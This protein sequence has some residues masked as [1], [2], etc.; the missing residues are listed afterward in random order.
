MA[1]NGSKRFS[2]IRKGMNVRTAYLVMEKWLLQVEE[3][4]KK[5]KQNII[6]IKCQ[7]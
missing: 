1:R 4:R 7:K 6:H 3:K 5:R 2:N